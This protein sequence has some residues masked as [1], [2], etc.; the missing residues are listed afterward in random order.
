MFLLLLIILII[1]TDSR[2][3]AGVGDSHPGQPDPRPG[4]LTVCRPQG[5][6]GYSDAVGLGV[7]AGWSQDNGMKV[8]HWLRHWASSGDPA[9]HFRFGVS[10]VL[11]ELALQGTRKPLTVT[12]FSSP[13]L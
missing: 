3:G 8:S 2:L 11:S 13:L 5:S 9:W 7:V 6:S 4:V 12:L 10:Q 1:T